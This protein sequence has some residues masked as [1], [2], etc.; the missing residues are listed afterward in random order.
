MAVAPGTGGGSAPKAAAPPAKK[1]ASDSTRRTTTP[2][3]TPAK[4]PAKKAPATPAKKT[5]TAP[6]AKTYADYGYVKG[7]LDAHHDV[8]DKVNAAIKAGWTPDRLA[9]EIKATK[10]WSTRTDSQRQ[11]DMLSVEQ[12]AQ[13]DKKVGDAT[14]SLR[15]MAAKMGVTLSDTDAA[16]LGVKMVRDGLTQQGALLALANHIQ[17]PVPGTDGKEAPMAGEAGVTVDTLRQMASDY[18]VHVQD[19]DLLAMTQKVQAGLVDPK[20]YEDTFRESAKALYAPIADVLDK[21]TTL[22]QFVSPY[23]QIASQQ[24]GATADM[25]PLSDSKWTGMIAEGRVLSADEWTRK[26]R[27]DAQ[28][29]WNQS[30]GAKRESMNLVQSLGQMFGSA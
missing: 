16:A 7:F 15:G 27:T 5:T 13:A 25:M 23:L 10:W 28:Y 9:G 26:L 11:Y 21:G 1:A 18:G 4:A 12:K 20:A 6:K 29:N 8:R 2:T 14:E 22:K 30:E 24:L 19:A 17:L 3:R